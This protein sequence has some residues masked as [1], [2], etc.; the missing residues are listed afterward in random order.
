MPNNFQFENNYILENDRVIL[1]TL[2][3]NNSTHLLK[4]AITE[5]DIWKFSLVPVAGE[6]NFKKY[7]AAADLLRQQKSAY[8]F[9]VYDKRF[10]EYAGSTRFYYI[11][12]NYST[13]QLGYT[14]YA[15]KFQGTGLNANCKY[16]LLKF[17]FEDMEME[18]VEFRADK[19]NARSIAAMKG[20]GCTIEGI[21]RN[22][23]PI[24]AGGRRDSII[25][26]I[27]KNEWFDKVKEKLEK[28]LLQLK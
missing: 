8:P 15:S 27:L 9:I 1:K 20:I 26:S 4:Y 19:N 2:D 3:G 17:A 13:L 24:E 11:Q 21:L 16:L 25:L 18:R 7:I 6:E 22:N 10:K 5:P 28:K 12:L 23:V 14:W